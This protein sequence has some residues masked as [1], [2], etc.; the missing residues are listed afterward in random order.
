MLDCWEIL[1]TNLFSRLR[2]S[3]FIGT[4]RKLNHSSNW[5]KSTSP[6]P[7]YHSRL[8]CAQFCS[9]YSWDHILWSW[10]ADAWVSRW[11][12]SGPSCP[13]WPAAIGEFWSLFFFLIFYLH[14][15]LHQVLAAAHGIFD[16]HC[17]MWDLVPR[18]ESKPRLLALGTHSL[19]HWTT[20]EVPEV[21]FL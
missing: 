4:G 2:T 7:E 10:P 11:D 3:P 15:W 21:L 13:A 9:E 18:P 1:K 16:F 12:L 5:R 17:R 8:S 20:R 14:I 19:S 6:G